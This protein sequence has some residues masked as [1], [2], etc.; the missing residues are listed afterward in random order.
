VS[1][2]GSGP[3]VP[4]P[5][6]ATTPVRVSLPVSVPYVTYTIIGP[7][8][9]FYLLQLGSVWLWDTSPVGMDADGLGARVNQ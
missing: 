4:V 2:Y 1:Q 6:A 8:V 7:T 3:D 5:A 9:L